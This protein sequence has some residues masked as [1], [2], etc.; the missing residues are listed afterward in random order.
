MINLC[1]F[2]DG[3]E[4]MENSISICFKIPLL[5][6]TTVAT[7]NSLAKEFTVSFEV[8]P[9]SLYSNWTN[10]I[11]LTTGG[12][13]ENFGDRNPAVFF[14]PNKNN[15]HIAS[16]IDNESNSI[17]DTACIPLKQ[18]SSI[19]ISQ[20]LVNQ[21]YTYCIRVNESIVYSV[22]NNIP[23]ELSNVKV[24]AGDP[25]YA[26]QNG[27]IRNLIITSK[28]PTYGTNILCKS[29]KTLEFLKYFAINILQINFYFILECLKL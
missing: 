27:F 22:V 4:T 26:A 28:S 23:L 11:H 17:F 1:F 7:L 25:W 13:V 5:H 29:F 16:A 18:W 21:S 20:Q 15:L 10:V 6:N 19:E 9:T 2:V 8:Y 3:I 12:N 14:L 24:Y